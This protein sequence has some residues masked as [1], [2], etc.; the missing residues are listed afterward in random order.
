MS[1]PARARV[2]VIS[3]QPL[4]HLSPE[5]RARLVG[6]VHVRDITDADALE[7]ALRHLGAAVFD[8]RIDCCFAAYEQAQYPLAIARERLGIAGMPSAV[9]MRFRDKSVMK[10]LLREAGIPVAR[11]ALVSSQADAEEFA[12]MV[13]FPI[14]IKPPAGAGARSTYRISSDADLQAL[15]EWL[16][17]STE[18]PM[19]AEEFLQGREHSLETV[20]I[21]GMAV[22]QSVS[23]YAPTPLEVLEN[24]WIQWTVLLPANVYSDE[25]K[26]IRHLGAKALKVLGMETGFSHCEWFRRSDG[27]LAISEIAAR[28]PGAQITTMISRANDVDIIRDWVALMMFGEFALP[29]QK[30]AVGTA[31]L[32]GQ[33]LAGGRVVAIEG[34]DLVEREFGSIVCDHRLPNYGQEPTGSYE[35]EGFIV[36]RHK[37]TEVVRRALKRIVDVVR[38]RLA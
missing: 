7:G 8:G 22:W 38:V 4:Q 13:G 3:Q 33:G 11:H 21:G 30:Y 32:R 6:H 2:A 14:V 35:G 34:L 16:D 27:S 1:L 19:L 23:S 31:Y 26:E 15:F 28:P 37:D 20:T 25:W 10:D 17:T 18:E 29:V 5:I 12:G 24:P 36:V 9:A